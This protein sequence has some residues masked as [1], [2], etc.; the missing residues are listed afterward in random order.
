VRNR[1]PIS[2][3]APLRLG[4]GITFYTGQLT[5][6]GL[7][8]RRIC[9]RLRGELRADQ[10]RSAA[11]RTDGVE[12]SVRGAVPAS[13]RRRHIAANSVQT[14]EFAG[15]FGNGLNVPNMNLDEART[16]FGR[17]PLLAQHCQ[18]FRNLLQIF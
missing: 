2:L 6:I 13:R 15:P 5:D 17:V 12:P 14:S 4:S 9:R 11:D 1:L 16:V 3:K 7:F 8:E 10:L 18:S